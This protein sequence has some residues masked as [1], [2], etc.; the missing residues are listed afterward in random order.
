M[1]KTYLIIAIALLGL[2]AVFLLKEEKAQKT[3]TI[4]ILQTASHPALDEVYQG[5]K[6]E[7]ERLTQNDVEL[8][9]YNAQGS[10]TNGYSAAQ[11]LTTAKKYTA[12]FAIAT[13]AAQALHALEKSRPVVF[14]AVTDPKAIGLLDDAPNIAGTSDMIDIPGTVAMVTTLIPTAKTIGLLYTSGEANSLSAAKALRTA[15]EQKGLEVTDFAAT[16]ELD[17]ATVAEGAFRKSDAVIAPTDNTVASSITVLSA[18]ALKAQKPFFVSDN[19]LVKFGPLAAQGINY[20]T[21]GKESAE[22]L[23]SIIKGKKSADGTVNSMTCQ[24]IYVNQETLKALNLT[25]PETLNVI[26]ITNEK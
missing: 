7:L 18:T 16:S 17:I 3:Y 25:L 11:Q 10:I 19:T 5:F 9:A 2:G 24:D 21:C 23:H 26:L 8:V 6:E 12:F 22:L 1:N 14:A 20:K 4:G 15:C 13:P